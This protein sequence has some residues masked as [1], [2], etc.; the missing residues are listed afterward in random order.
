MST[1]GRRTG[2][3]LT[4]HTRIEFEDGTDKDTIAKLDA[5]IPWWQAAVEDIWDDH[6]A[7]WRKLWCRVHFT[8]EM[9]EREG[10][11][12]AGWHQVRIVEAPFRS[13]SEIGPSSGE[14]AWSLYTDEYEAAHEVGHLMGLPAD[15]TGLMGQSGSCDEYTVKVLPND[16]VVYDQNLHPQSTDPQCIMAQTWAPAAVVPPHVSEILQLVGLSCRKRCC[17][18]RLWDR[19]RAPRWQDP[20]PA[21]GADRFRFRDLRDRSVAEVLDAVEAARPMTLSLVA[22]ELARR[23][24]GVVGDLLEPAR[25]GTPLQRLT[26]ALALQA[27]GLDD[28][29]TVPVLERMLASGDPGLRL[30]AGY[31]LA[32][33][34]RPGGRESLEAAKDL[35]VVV[36]G[37][38]PARAS[39]L[40]TRMLT[41]LRGAREG[42]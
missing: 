35:D 28:E 17:F 27:S 19:A 15:C 38:P 20:V 7:G 42:R 31:A 40:A 30:H 29:R 25:D 1:T 4:V 34:G 37:H 2:C 6:G 16:D 32:R 26:V 36:A 5:R 3:A 22:H 39:D 24:E 14:G 9:R 13:W 8:F 11:P 41:S 33:R 23:G 10:G 18:L 21:A 12:T